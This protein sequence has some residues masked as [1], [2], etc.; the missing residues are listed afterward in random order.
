MGSEISMSGESRFPPFAQF[1]PFDRILLNLCPK[2]NMTRIKKIA[3][4][5]SGL[6]VF[7]EQKSHG[8]QAMIS[9]MR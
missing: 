9:L 3:L 6:I 1:L 5:R 7:P 2:R 8:N 4:V